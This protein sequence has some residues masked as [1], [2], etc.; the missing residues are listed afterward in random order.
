MLGADLITIGVKNQAPQ[1]SFKNSIVGD[2][3]SVS[4]HEF[5]DIKC[6]NF[7]YILD[8]KSY[9]RS[10]TFSLHDPMPH[11]LSYMVTCSFLQNSSKNGGHHHSLGADITTFVL[12]SQAPKDSF[13]PDLT[14]LGSK[15]KLKGH[16]HS[17]S[18]QC[19]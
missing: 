13:G 15:F 5:V 8:S 7:L 17:L 16:L 4:S 12:S 18:Y 2:S 19:I 11:S 14:F 1:V 3:I 6:C 9:Y 10:H